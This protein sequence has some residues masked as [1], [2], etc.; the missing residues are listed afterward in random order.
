[1]VN[2]I[3]K[4]LAAKK[5]TQ[6][7]IAKM[8]GVTPA[9]VHYVVSGKRRNPRIR[10]ALSMATGRPVSEL[11]PEDNAEQSKRLA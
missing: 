6:T 2:L 3:K 10:L 7:D 5:V 11:W 4:S 9:A 1:M 8:L